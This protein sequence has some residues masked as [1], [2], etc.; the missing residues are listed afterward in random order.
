V[1]CASDV[2]TA[3]AAALQLNCS[4]KHHKCAPCD[5]GAA[6]YV[7]AGGSAYFI[8]DSNTGESTV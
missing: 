2:L 6:V 5:V 3:I 1:V 4:C 8:I 7:C